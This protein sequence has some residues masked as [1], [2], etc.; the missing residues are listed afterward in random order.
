M[1]IGGLNDG[2]NWAKQ[3]QALVFMCLDSGF[4]RV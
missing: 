2:R 4:R 1:F 3:I